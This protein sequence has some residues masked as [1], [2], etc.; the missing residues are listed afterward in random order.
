MT[1]PLH[2]INFELYEQIMPKN[3][4]WL[5]NAVINEK[6]NIGV[7]VKY[8]PSELPF[9]SQWKMLGEQDYVVGLEP[10]NTLP[11]GIAKAAED[12]TAR[13]VQPKEKI[14]INLQIGIVDGEEEIK[15]LKNKI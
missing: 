12:G 1:G 15:N 10:G 4:P 3:K 5:Y 13:I 14:E 6:L 2:D 11:V 8:D 7:Y 9:A